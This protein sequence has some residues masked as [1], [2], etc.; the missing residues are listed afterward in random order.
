MHACVD[1]ILTSTGA[2]SFSFASHEDG[3][4]GVPRTRAMHVRGTNLTKEASRKEAATTRDD[5]KTR[6]FALLA[7]T[8]Q[9]PRVQSVLK[10]GQVLEKQ[11]MPVD[12]FD[13]WAA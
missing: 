5:K 9:I 10:S 4:L 2:I 1:G 3:G 7:Q 8:S 13:S 11:M 12:S 6:V